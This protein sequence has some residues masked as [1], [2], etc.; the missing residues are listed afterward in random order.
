MFDIQEFNRRIVTEIRL[1]PHKFL[2]KECG[3]KA[4]VEYS[5]NMTDNTI[6]IHKK[7]YNCGNIFDEKTCE[8]IQ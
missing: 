7:C 8:I 2:C 5:N 6:T 3:H 1:H 4:I